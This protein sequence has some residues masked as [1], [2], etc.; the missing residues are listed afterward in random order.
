MI[1]I[2]RSLRKKSSPGRVMHA[3][4][5]HAYTQVIISIVNILIYIEERVHVNIECMMNRHCL[6]VEHGLVT[7]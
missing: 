6:G 2:I 3:S 1:L 4:S 7:A 5:T